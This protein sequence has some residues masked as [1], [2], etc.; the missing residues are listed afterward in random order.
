MPDFSGFYE[1]SH[2]TNK[3]TYDPADSRERSINRDI[4]IRIREDYNSKYYI[5]INTPI[6]SIVVDT[7]RVNNLIPTDKLSEAIKKII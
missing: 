6:K 5:Y 4:F 7:Y 1:Q 2:T 3:I